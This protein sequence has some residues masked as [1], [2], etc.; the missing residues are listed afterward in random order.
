MTN[1]EKATRATLLQFILDSLGATELNPIKQVKTVP[2]AFT[3]EW[4][5]EVKMEDGVKKILSV[6]ITESDE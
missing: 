3:D 1:L 6:T 5:L 4:D 2:G